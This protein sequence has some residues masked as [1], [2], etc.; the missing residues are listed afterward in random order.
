MDGDR[1]ESTEKKTALQVREETVG[2]RKP[3][4][5]LKEE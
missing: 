3:E 5:R 2:K 4:T 1:G